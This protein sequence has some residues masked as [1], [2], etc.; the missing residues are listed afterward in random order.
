M[1][2]LPILIQV[3]GEAQE[4]AFLAS[5]QAMLLPPPLFLK[6]G[7]AQ[8]GPGGDQTGNFVLVARALTNWANRPPVLT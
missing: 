3:W 1:G 7:A 5:P 8:S 2:A 4:F 6:K